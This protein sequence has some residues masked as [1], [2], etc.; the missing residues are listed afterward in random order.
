MMA[1]TSKPAAGRSCT[2]LNIAHSCHI[3]PLNHVQSIT[4]SRHRVSRTARRAIA[5]ADD[6]G[7]AAS[8]AAS[9][10]AAANEQ[11]HHGLRVVLVN[12]QIPQNAGNA[13]RS[14][15]AAGAGLHLVGPL[16]FDISDKQLK[17]AGL[18]YWEHGALLFGALCVVW[19]YERCG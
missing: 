14:C 13:A 5:A 9:A 6:G 16:G 8:A 3:G 7:A 15:A 12:P 10:A 4:G 18:D 1:S 19:L 11:Q 2:S 17:R